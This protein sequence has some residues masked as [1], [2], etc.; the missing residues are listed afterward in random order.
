MVDFPQAGTGAS[1]RHGLSHRA[2]TT[3]WVYGRAPGDPASWGR[4]F[5][6]EAETAEVLR[7]NRRVCGVTAEQ[8]TGWVCSQEGSGILG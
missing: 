1:G 4:G 7:S 8:S 2:R 3:G 5:L 6:E